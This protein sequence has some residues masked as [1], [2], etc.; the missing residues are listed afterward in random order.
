MN[1]MTKQNEV[2]LT[3]KELEKLG[4]K[5]A[6]IEAYLVQQN[7]TLNFIPGANEVKKDEALVRYHFVDEFLTDTHLSNQTVIKELGE[8]AVMLLNADDLA[9]LNALKEEN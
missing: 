2:E 7:H 6:R 1:N 9:E 5:L 3:A 4:E 8:I